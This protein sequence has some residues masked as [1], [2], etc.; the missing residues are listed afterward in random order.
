MKNALKRNKKKIQER[1]YFNIRRVLRKKKLG[2]NTQAQYMQQ[3]L[4]SI[5]HRTETKFTTKKLNK[6]QDFNTL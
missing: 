2:A 6:F 3:Q 1:G 4:F 5:E